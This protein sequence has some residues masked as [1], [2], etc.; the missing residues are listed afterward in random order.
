[1]RFEP[2]PTDVEMGPDGM[3]YVSTLPGGPE[4]GSLGANGSVYRVDPRSG[5]ATWLAGGMHGATG[6]AVHG[7]DIVVAEMFAGEVSVIRK[8]TTT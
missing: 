5:R 8:G 1:M 6:L 4:D 2:V 7:R 3:L